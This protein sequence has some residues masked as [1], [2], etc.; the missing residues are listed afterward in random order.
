MKT[1]V[2]NITIKSVTWLVI[3]MMGM[4]IANT[5]VF[6]H[7][8]KLSDGTV[9]KHAHP[10]NKTNDSAPYKSHH[11]SKAEFLFL[12]NLEILFLLMFLTFALLTF[13][14]R[15]KNK[16]YIIT[17]NSLNCIILHKGRAPPIS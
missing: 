12:Q 2:R 7:T 9:I 8:H 5:A 4:L 15:V 3:G 16:F 10:Y 17:R 6:I 1:I 14:K 11:H 13:A